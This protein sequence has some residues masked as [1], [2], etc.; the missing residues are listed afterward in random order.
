MT[1]KV[2]LHCMSTCLLIFLLWHWLEFESNQLTYH[3]GAALSD[4]CENNFK[5]A[6]IARFRTNC[7]IKGSLF[8]SAH[9]PQWALLKIWALNTNVCLTYPTHTPVDTFAVCLS[10]KHWR[11]FQLSN[12]Q[13]RFDDTP[14]GK[15]WIPLSFEQFCWCLSRD[16]SL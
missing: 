3:S 12:L 7:D 9:H 10:R 16:V 6:P 14:C 4:L 13:D 5:S 11:T 1:S 8:N 2:M 15:A